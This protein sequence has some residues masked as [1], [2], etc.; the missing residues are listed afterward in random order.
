MGEV[1]QWCDSYSIAAEAHTEGSP[2]FIRRLRPATRAGRYRPGS[3]AGNLD[4]RGCTMQVI[5]ISIP[6]SK[7]DC[8][9]RRTF[10]ELHHSPSQLGTLW[11]LS[12]RFIRELFR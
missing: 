3:F 8:Q 11:G 1:P 10:L 7:G 12:A 6:S 2:Q 5:P 9:P 4:S